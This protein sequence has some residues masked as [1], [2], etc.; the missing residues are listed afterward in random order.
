MSDLLRVLHVVPYFPPDRI[1]GVGEVAAH[2]H[3][4]LLTRGHK[5]Q[6]I[7]SGTTTEDPRVRRIASSPSAF[8]LKC[9][10]QAGFLREFDV[11]HCHHG[12]ALALLLANWIRGRIPVLLTLHCS[13]S[14]IARSHRPYE[15]AGRQFGRD[16]KARRQRLAIAP[17]RHLLDL[18]A[19]RL[20]TRVNFISRHG[21][22]D[23]LGPDAGR[24]AD[25]VYY[26][27]PELTNTAGDLNEATATLAP[28]PEPVDLL[29]A[30]AANHRKR[31]YALPFILAR[32]R[33]KLPN[34]RLR[35]V[36]FRVEGDRRLVELFRELQV[37]DAVI[38]EGPKRSDQLAPYYR[39]AKVLLVP[40]AH[41][42]LPMVMIESLQCGTPCIATNV[43]GHPEIIEQGVNG[44]L[45]DVD[46][47]DQMADR[48]I[49][50]LS[51]DNLHCTMSAA[52]PRIVRERFGLER[53]ANEY[54]ALYESLCA[55][56]RSKRIVQ[57][58]P[59][60]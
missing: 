37:L 32:V 53:E 58:A 20:S 50:I 19:M 7:T 25:V 9:A 34:V 28:T 8:A 27:L 1:G 35:I 41:E 21:A 45:V 29:Y 44:F 48:V 43:S 31:I 18:A 46:R 51:N 24:S 57:R 4:E 42:G 2:M 54:L 14:G 6:V 36:G 12:E 22:I 39:A 33:E 47:P 23:F 30:G 11:V 55:E 26:G 40:S 3:R 56:R 5:S 60:D 49:E 15:L 38:C 17:A 59:H 52:A 10:A 13:C 16:A